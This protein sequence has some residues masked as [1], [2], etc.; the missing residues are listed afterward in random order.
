MDRTTSV[1]GGVLLTSSPE[2]LRTSMG[3]ETERPLPFAFPKPSIRRPSLTV[4]WPKGTLH[5]VPERGGACFL[6]EQGMNREVV[7]FSSG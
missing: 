3:R 5:A 2:E 1:S 4:L 7:H 6:Q